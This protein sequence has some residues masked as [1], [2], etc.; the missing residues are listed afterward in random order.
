MGTITGP[1]NG[2]S[3]ASIITNP[4][5]F[6][7][8]LE[9]LEGA[10]EEERKTLNGNH[11][12]NI[13]ILSNNGTNQ[14]LLNNRGSHSNQQRQQQL[15]KSKGHF[16]F[17]QTNSS[18]RASAN[19]PVGLYSTP[20]GSSRGI[21]Q[22]NNSQYTI[23]E[24][25]SQLGLL[26]QHFNYN[27]LYMGVTDHQ[28]QQQQEQNVVNILRGN[29]YD[30]EAANDDLLK[31][32]YQ[33]SD[34]TNEIISGI[35]SRSSRKS[36][37]RQ[38]LVTSL[39]NDSNLNLCQSGS[40]TQ[41]NP[42]RLA[43]PDID[44]D[45]SFSV[46]SLSSGASNLLSSQSAIHLVNPR[47]RANQVSS[48]TN[49]QQIPLVEM[50][51]F[52]QQQQQP[53]QRQQPMQLQFWNDI[54]KTSRLNNQQTDRNILGTN[55]QGQDGNFQHPSN[56]N[57]NNLMQV[58][59]SED[60]GLFIDCQNQR[61]SMNGTLDD[62]HNSMNVCDSE[63]F[64]GQINMLTADDCFTTTDDLNGFAGSS[65]DGFLLSQNRV[66]HKETEDR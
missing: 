8:T 12:T 20:K 15:A 60:C 54:R 29:E 52:M 6:E 49:R 46:D 37:L 27:P 51:S 36:S 35:E 5:A 32:I 33:Y 64:E 63:T 19:A 4:Q 48:V 55:Q 17:N 22:I 50:Q 14:R 21:S 31:D 24:Q 13:Q 30:H 7:Q 66:P 61:G 18:I 45:S 44:P 62:L 53:Q 42:K 38:H 39:F 3:S 43:S 1:T 25:N 11:N 57:F 28:Q 58:D 34:L 56:G 16:P 41:A 23:I 40:S 9:S 65:N 26:N 59:I 47:K 2:S 10:E